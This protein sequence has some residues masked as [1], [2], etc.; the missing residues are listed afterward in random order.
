MSLKSDLNSL[1]AELVKQARTTPDLETKEKVD[2]FKAASAWYLGSVKVEKPKDTDE[3]S[4]TFD[5]L[6]SRVG[7]G[8]GAVQ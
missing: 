7:L 3:D 8:K 2:I 5:T 6:R 1:A 4:P